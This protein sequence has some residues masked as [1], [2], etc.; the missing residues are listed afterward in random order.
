MKKDKKTKEIPEF[1]FGDLK[2]SLNQALHHAQGKLTCRTTKLPQPIKEI[3]PKQIKAI[4]N[5]LNVSQSVFAA[6]LNVPAKTAISWESGARKPTRAA[7]RLLDIA[8]KHPEA[9]LEV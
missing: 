8:E 5:K 1:N 7:L 4:R 9:L 2:L 3:S 6:L